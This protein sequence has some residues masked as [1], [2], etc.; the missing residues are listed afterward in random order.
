[1]CGH[2]VS[3]LSDTRHS[4]KVLDNCDR[5]NPTKVRRVRCVMWGA[6][7]G[8]M[9]CCVQPPDAVRPAPLIEVSKESELTVNGER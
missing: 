7:L 4:F 1:M 3:W 5:S 2:F 8:S 9:V 6:Q